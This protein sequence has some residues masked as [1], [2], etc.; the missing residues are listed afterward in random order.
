MSR[1]ARPGGAQLQ[2]YLRWA[3]SPANLLFG[4]CLVVLYLLVAREPAV[5]ILAIVV[6]LNS[7]LAMGA[8]RL[9]GQE[10]VAEA[11]LVY[12]AGVWMVSVAVGTTGLP[13]LSVATV[14]AILA[15]IAAVPYVGSRML[16]GMSL[17]TT[18]TVVINCVWLVAEPPLEPRRLSEGFVR[19]VVASGVSALAGLCGLSLWHNK[20]GLDEATA[21]LE[22]ANRALRESE[23][24]L[25]L[26]VRERTTELEHSRQELAAAR[27][28][29]LAANRHKSAFLANMSHELRTPLNAIIG[30]S[31]VLGTRLFGPLSD[32]QA[33]YVEDIHASGHHLLSLINDILDLSKI[34]AGRLE[35]RWSTFDLSAAVDNVLTLMRERASRAGLRL[36][37]ELSPA[38][39]A[40]TADERAVKQI[41]INLLT[42]AVKFT[43]RGGA[44]TVHAAPNGQEVVIAVADTGIGIAP[45]DQ[46]LIFQEFRQGRS[47]YTRKQEGTGLGLAL[48]KR[49]V[50]LHGGRIW[51]ESEPGRGSTFRFTLPGGTAPGTRLEG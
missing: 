44:V 21:Q 36:G 33:E 31:E 27:D 35:L 26:K 2:Q 12:A 20:R 34:E 51:V 32:K 46:A 28:E 25:E 45:D 39:G 10:R 14:V 38:L 5:L 1:V 19:L 24:G 15:V 41:L 40:V 50:E 49:L 8:Y 9:A 37:K 18:A 4:V 48:S 3:G 6:G 16:L 30:F 29:A 13:L 42:N 11:A 23:R 17:V 22:T 7:L 43:D 47:D